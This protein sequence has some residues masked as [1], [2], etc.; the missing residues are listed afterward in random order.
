MPLTAATRASRKPDIVF[1]LVIM[2]LGAAVVFEASK[3]RA[4]PFDPL[5]PG[6]VPMGVGALLFVF[7]LYVLVSAVFGAGVGGGQ[8]MFSGLEDEDAEQPLR[9]GRSIAVYAFSLV[10]LAVLPL[11]AVDFLPA[12][13]VYMIVLLLFLGDRSWRSL[14]IAVLL[15]VPLAYTLDQVF[16][17]VLSVNLP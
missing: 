13:I 1:A 8:R 17:R 15:S 10:Y 6:G 12:T 5:G 9:W 11:R 14:L 7:A 2:A 4:S 16:R 3:L